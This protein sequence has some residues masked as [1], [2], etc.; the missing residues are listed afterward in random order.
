[1][2]I[3]SRLAALACAMPI[4]LFVAAQCDAVHPPQPLVLHAAE[5]PVVERGGPSPYLVPTVVHIHYGGGVQP[6]G[7]MHVQPILDH[8][9]ADLRALNDDLA[10]VIPEF[11]DVV[12]DLG[13]ELRLATRDEQGDCFS[14]IQYHYYDPDGGFP[15]TNGITFNTRTYLNIHIVPATNSFATY[16]S[17]IAGPYDAGD[18]IVLSA[19][20]A[21]FRPRSL[22]HEV[23]HWLGLYH[24]FGPVNT[25]AV[26]CGDDYIAD[27]PETAG[28]AVGSCDL[29][30]STCT[31]GVVENAQNHMDYSTCGL[32]FT[33]GQAQHA[34]A[35][36]ADELLVRSLTVDPANLIATGVTAP[37]SC[38]I[39]AG[40][41]SRPFIQCGGSTVS[42][43]AMAEGAVPDSL[44]WTFTGGS[45]A[46]STDDHASV[47]Y[48][49]GG[50]YNVQLTVY[51]SGTSATV[52]TTLTVEV[53][54]PNANGFSVIDSYPYTEGFENGFSLPAA[55]MQ[56]TPSTSPTWQPFTQAGHAS[57]NSL[58]VPPEP[59][60]VADTNVVV[61]GNFDMSSLAQATVQLK[62]ASSSYTF[63]GWS[64]LQ[65]LFRDLCS[66]TF[67]GNIWAVWQLNEMA[68]DQ[69]M[70][71]VPDNDE[72]WVTLT[73]TRPEWNLAE[74]AEFALRL[75][76]PAM[77]PAFTPE[78]FYIDDLY[79][80]ELPTL[81]GI[82]TVAGTPA[83]V[84][85]PNPAPGHIT[86]QV[87]GPLAP[88]ARLRVLD[89]LGRVVADGPARQGTHRLAEGVAPGLYT[90]SDGRHAVRVVVE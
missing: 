56:A 59:S 32:M 74:G 25:S 79:I 1:M 60:T 12:G 28:S 80:G 38:P 16:P 9:N 44:R 84:V 86:V 49:T 52:N 55:H 82:A 88:G 58:Y 69:G 33:Q 73:V 57:A 64:T 27:T 54:D 19:Y 24:T 71:F 89:Q 63:S 34:L 15:Q 36:L 22:A 48:T 6:L 46:T 70:G 41:Y 68:T 77:P 29:G 39:T 30:L 20:D 17:P 3:F 66:N 23:G 18:Y 42:F 8:C 62:V 53:P 90:V 76:R 10:D 21:V 81:T 5:R 40:I 26:A 85:A 47:L 11:A 83:F 75:I 50:D 72:Q 14:G 13:L 78:A 61:I 2:P 31:P 51:G 37:A 87:H 35:V 7:V 43:R 65:L 67:T 45:P 4:S